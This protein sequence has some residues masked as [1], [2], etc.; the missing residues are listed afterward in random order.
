MTRGS[1]V[2]PVCRSKTK[3]CSTTDRRVAKGL[4]GISRDERMIEP[5][6]V[7]LGAVERRCACRRGDFELGD[8]RQFL[9][10]D[11]DQFECVLGLRP[12]LGDDG[13]DGL[14][15]PAHFAAGEWILRRR[16][17]AGKQRQLCLPR[18]ADRSEIV[19]SHDRNNP[20]R[21]S[22]RRGID[23]GG[24]VHAD[25]GCAGTRC[26]RR[27]PHRCRRC[28]GLCPL[29]GVCAS[30]R[31]SAAPDPVAA[32][33]SWPRLRRSC[34]NGFDR[35]DDR[36]IASAAAE[37][38]R[39]CLADFRPRR[40][41]PAQAIRPRSTSMP[42]VQYPHCSAL[43][44]TNSRCRSAMALRSVS[45]SMVSTMAPSAC[46]A[47]IRQLRTERPSIMTLQAPQTPCSQPTWVP[48]RRSV[49]RRKSAR[50]RRAATE[51]QTGL[52]LS[53]KAMS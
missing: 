28:N 17:V 39:Q 52:P 7:G 22:G 30:R 21:L 26:G 34:R 9:P 33:R 14:A 11:L 10:F 20:R 51:A 24:C 3:S 2:T 13:D 37:I 49:W 36:L 8:G 5:K 42:G 25:T 29:R 27:L 15:L 46:T 4:I 1:S 44:A 35:I 32:C 48:V 23:R 45:P 50:C 43:R 6:I 18:L 53:V 12:G 31:G 47:S 41:G 38:A 16:T 40:I 19:A